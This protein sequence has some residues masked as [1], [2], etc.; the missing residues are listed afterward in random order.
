[1]LRKKIALTIALMVYSFLT[2]GQWTQIGQNIEGE[3]D[4]N[5]SGWSVSLSSDGSIVAIGAP[6]NDGNGTY[7]GHVRIFQNQS[8]TWTQIGQ[9]IDGENMSDSS[10]F[11]L[12]LSSNGSI[13]AIGSPFKDGNGT[14][15]GHVRIFQNQSGTWNQIGEDIDGE[16]ISDESGFSLSLSS[17]GSIV[18]IGSP[19]NDGNGNSSGHVRV[20]QNQS[21]TWNQIGQDIDG[22]NIN[23]HSGRSLSLSSDGSI[24]AIGSPFNDDNGLNSG[25]VRIF[26]NQSGTW[27][28]IGQNINGEISEDLFGWSVSLSSNGSIIAISAV[29]SVGTSNDSGLV[30]VY[31]NQSGT[32][33][34]IGQDIN[35]ESINDFSGF[36]VSLS[37]DGAIIAIGASRNDGNGNSS[38][39]VRVFQNQ[40]ETWTQ[41]EQD[42]DGERIG[43]SSGYS[44][45]LSS[46]GSIVAIGSPFNNGNGTSSGHTRVFEK[47]VTL[48]NNPIK[49]ESYKIQ[50]INS[51]IILLNGEKLKL[52]IYLLNGNEIKNEN[53]KVGIYI[54]K[55]TDNL[56]KLLTKKI[57][58]K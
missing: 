26:Q 58:L 28:Q 56:G 14:N 3:L 44:V 36:S 5:V 33:N 31:E 42:I 48:S 24:V 30:R 9:D 22:E 1:M 35:G 50:F 7:S 6:R 8:G 12:S 11:S 27:N 10:G 2:F 17:N 25:H 40:S 21:G 54:I 43:D 20:F 29:G 41:I 18:A 45:S 52:N 15:S 38:G 34:Q 57:L 55:I 51:K 39:H 49:L 4:D 47:M 46:D 19:F 32:W 37:S 16:N 23:D 13:V 53:L